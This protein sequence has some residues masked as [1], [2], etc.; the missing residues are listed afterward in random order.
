MK[1]WSKDWISSKN[2][3]KQRKYRYNAPLHI[4]QRFMNVHL[5]P[6]LRKKYGKRSITVR[7][8]DKVI[9]LKGQFKKK[10]GKVSEVKLKRGK[11]FVE[12]IEHIKKDG[13]KALYALNPT[14]LMITE[15]ILDD[16]M[17]KKKLV[18]VEEKKNG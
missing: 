15:L 5:S 8:G 14:N 1:E 11:V 6:E 10:T 17:R 13:S 7:T 12:G 2:P 9:I 16:K 4:Q 18:K 3:A